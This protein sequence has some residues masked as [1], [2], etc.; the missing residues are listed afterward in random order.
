MAG[1]FSGKKEKKQGSLASVYADSFSYLKET[2]RFTF[3]IISIFL[4]SAAVGYMFPSLFED[5]VNKIILD[6]ISKIEG[7]NFFQ[8][9]FYIIKNNLMTS[10]VGLVFGVFIGIYPVSVAILNGYI[11]GYVLNKSVSV[12][13][14]AAL[15]RLL[16]HGIFEL[17]A[18]FISLGM[19]LN[20][21]MTLF[22]KHRKKYFM[23]HIEK[24]LKVFL[25]IVVPLLIL[26]GIIETLLIFLP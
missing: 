7:Y 8:M 1:K 19:G 6:I 24:S 15:F 20:L 22:K 4:V 3:I 11:L 14:F 13:G 21:G 17:P 12:I 23:E 25:A 9:L 10:L 5:V 2:R 16:P 18:I 26:A